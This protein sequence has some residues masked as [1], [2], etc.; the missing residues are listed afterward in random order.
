MFKRKDWLFTHG[1]DGGGSDS[2]SSDDGS[3]RSEG[4][5]KGAGRS[6]MHALQ[7][8][9]AAPEVLHCSP[10]PLQVTLEARN[11][12]PTASSLQQVGRRSTAAAFAPPLLLSLHQA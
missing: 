7:A 11:P 1:A 5:A 10:L 3:S 6:R 12:K 2:S 9:L 4:E 8:C